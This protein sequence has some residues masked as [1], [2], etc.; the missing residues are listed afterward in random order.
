VIEYDREGST[1][2]MT[3]QELTDFLGDYVEGALPAQVRDTFEKHLTICPD[4]RR[5]LDSYRK[6]I[7]LAQAAVRAPAQAREIPQELIAA[8]LKAK[9]SRR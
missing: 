4:C 7:A 6:S 5:Y 9:G 1:R 3:C 8:I 2:L